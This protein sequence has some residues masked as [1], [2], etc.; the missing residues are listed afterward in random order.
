MIFDQHEPG[1]KRR[2]P[3]FP[4]ETGAAAGMPLPAEEAIKILIV[5]DEPRNLTALETVLDDPGYKLVRA[6][7]ANEA[8]LALVAEDFALLILD[9]QMPD[10]N[11]FELAMMIKQR[12][13]SASIPIIFLTAYSS[14]DQHLQEG[15]STGAVDFLQKPISPA[16]LRS[17]VSVF[18]DLHRKTLEIARTNRELLAEVSERRRAQEELREFNEQLERRVSARTAEL[19]ASEARFRT[20]AEEMPHL[21]WEMDAAGRITYQNSRSAAYATPEDHWMKSVHPDDAAQTSATWFAALTAG[22][23]CDLYCR[24]HRLD[25]GE[26]RWFHVKAAPARNAAG[27]IIRWVGTSTDIHEQRKAEEALRE[28]DR[29][30]DEFLAMLGHELRNPLAAI[31]HAVRMQAEVGSDDASQRWAG[32]VIDR[33]STQLTRMVDDLLDVERINRGRIELR[34]APVRL[35]AVVAAAVTAVMPLIELRKHSL[36]VDAADGILSVRG[37]AD[38]LEQVFVN[39]LTNAAKYTPEG[40][41]IRLSARVEHGSAVISVIDNGVGIAPELLPYVFDLFT[42][43]TTSLDRA[44]GGL[45]IGLTVVKSL[46]AMHGG[47]VTAESG[48]AGSG[49]TF[50]VM[51]PLLAPDKAA[52][53]SDTA[54]RA[55][56]KPA[57][58][59]TGAARPAGSSLPDGPPLSDMSDGSYQ[60]DKSDSSDLSDNFSKATPAASANPDTAASAQVPMPSGSGSPGKTKTPPEPPTG[61]LPRPVRVLIVDDHADAAQTLSRLLSR[62]NCE[63]RLAHDGPGGVEAAREFSPEVLLLDLGLPGFDG[64][65]VA[66]ILRADPVCADALFIA[67]S[68]Y[69][70]DSDRQRSAAAGFQHHCAKPVDFTALLA[71]IH[72]HLFAERA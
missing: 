34:F 47:S 44:Q 25:S 15:Y 46:V 28:A 70:Q 36:A 18:A 63:V 6:E 53:S 26:Y 10:M 68:G 22:R 30:K 20:L 17:K 66:R 32:E 40:G 16:I 11:G 19:T 48:E 29:R 71:V 33:Q 14:E 61:T 4:A 27:H 21:V 65:E 41:H 13:R 62:R 7:S 57:T 49:A 12:K 45:G 3:L 35:E 60:S 67:I 58:T 72:E 9:V 24:Q 56:A 50:T 5:D 37:D 42:Q 2:S 43:A 31:R 54:A 23:E 59:I 8:L 52:K 51:L 38:R 64:Y 55:A 1:E 39:L 69:A